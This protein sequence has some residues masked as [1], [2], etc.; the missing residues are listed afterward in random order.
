MKQIS[1]LWNGTGALATGKRLAAM[2]VVVVLLFP[3]NA[4]G[5]GLT[6]IISFLRTITSTLQGAIGGTLNEL[7]S[8]NAAVSHLHQQVVWPTT[9]INQTRNFVS[10]I[11]DRYKGVLSQIQHF[12]ANSATLTNPT[13]LETLF[14]SGSINRLKVRNRPECCADL[15]SVAQGLLECCCKCPSKSIKW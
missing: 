11:R 3:P 8:I 14:R 15:G 9:M 2:L 13:Q 4:R 1:R 7:Q 6:D 5:A 10:A 12:P